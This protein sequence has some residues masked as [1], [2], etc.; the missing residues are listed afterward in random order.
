[1]VDG[2]DP[3]TD[4]GRVE[5]HLAECAACREWRDAAHEVTRRARLQLAEHAPSRTDEVLAAV[6]ARMLAAR[7][8]VTVSL[9]RLALAAVAAGQLALTVPF[10]LFG[11]D[12]SAP[13]HV[14]REM[15]SFD[16]ALAAGFLVAA[17]RPARALGMRAV[18][19][20]AA[21]LL[22]VTAAVD[23]AMG[24]TSLADEAPH[25]LVVA[26]LLLVCYLAAATP[27][28]AED[29]MPV[30]SRLPGRWFRLR[31][32]GLRH[33][34]ALTAVAGPTAGWAVVSAAGSAPGKQPHRDDVPAACGCAGPH[35]DCPGCTGPGRAA[36][37]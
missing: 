27:P 35:C 7:P 14:A 37:G 32:G 8:A 19:A 29:T 5:V 31:P 24:R 13:V 34:A 26:G 23:L 21:V 18:V 28:M 20:V 1:M 17:W 11:H 33:T 25:L 12:H 9:A 6:H 3:G 22:A 4:S 16:A 15:G 30:R 10:L 36:T 2:E